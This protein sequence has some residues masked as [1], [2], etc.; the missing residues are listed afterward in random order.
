MPDC[1]SPRRDRRGDWVAI[2]VLTAVALGV[3]GFPALLGRPALPGDD[4][5][6]NYPLRV[7]A[8]QQIRAGQ[9]P[10]FDPYIWSGAPL[11]AGW[12]AAAAYPMTWLFAVLPGAAAWTAGLMATYEAAAGGMYAF[13]RLGLRLGPAASFAGALT[14]A[15]G[16]Q[17]GAQAAHFGLVAG[18]SWAPL[19]LLAVA[20]LTD[21]PER[22]PAMSAAAATD[23]RSLAAGNLA[24]E[25]SGGPGIADLAAALPGGEPAAG[26]GDLPPGLPEGMRTASGRATAPRGRTAA[27]R[28]MAVLGLAVGLIALAGEPRAI[29]DG[30]AVIAGY[31]AWQVA[32]LGRRGLGV[33]CRLAGGLA[34]GAALGAAQLLPGLAAIATSQRA[35]SSLALFSS[36]SLPDRWLLLMLAPD[37]LGG[38]GT[39][40]QPAFFGFY[41]LTEVSGYVGI[42]PLAAALALLARLPWAAAATR[43]RPAPP[44]PPDPG[45]LGRAI[46]TRVGRAGIFRAAIPAQS[47]AIP[48]RP[49]VPDWLVWHVVALSGL[50]LALGGNTPLGP[51]LARLPFLGTQRLQSRNLLVLDLALAVLLAYWADRPPPR[52]PSPR[53]CI[54]SPRWMRAV[55]GGR[56]GKAAE[57]PTVGLPATTTTPLARRTDT[58]PRHHGALYAAHS[59]PQASRDTPGLR[60]L[61]PARETALA[62]APPIAVIGVAAA[63]LA[64]PGLVH[65]LDGNDPIGAGL[66]GQLRPWLLPNLALGAGT[67]ALVTA[68]QRLAKGLRAALITGIVAVDLTVYS[69]LAV[70]Q[71]APHPAA[72]AS[73]AL[74]PPASPSAGRPAAGK[75]APAPV[76]ATPANPA[77]APGSPGRTSPSA[78][79]SRFAAPGAEAPASAAPMSPAPSAAGQAFPGASPRS[80]ARPVADLGY[81]GRF[82]IYDPDLLDPADLSALDPPDR[83]VAGGMASVQGY[84]SIVDGRYAAA[85]GSHLADGGGQ[86]TLSL[87]AISGAVLDELDTT[88]LLTLPRYAGGVLRDALRLPHWRP[89]GRDGPFEVFRNLRARPPLTLEA[90]G[91]GPAGGASVSDVTGPASTDPIQATVRDAGGIRIVRSVSGITGWTASWHPDGGRQAAL[92]VRADGLVQA[93]D[94]PPGTGVLTWRYEPPRLA[95]G[96]G[97]S[98]AA[99]LAIAALLIPARRPRRLL[100]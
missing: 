75:A 2:G 27:R 5:T 86:D 28:W 71:I 63:V 98:V 78:K 60:G 41:N 4:M 13:L 1:R 42:L 89:A 59:L 34:L 40:S 29:A 19:A 52:R 32:R 95:E 44:A 62:A 61:L 69:V 9:L 57:E 58:G 22:A 65:W 47:P 85:T 77:G 76:S 84:S 97:L 6:Q 35:G 53:V 79:A 56:A 17:M 37:L 16:G 73:A 38:S 7:L 39:L 50:A 10:L 45:A 18:M 20:R 3:F 92:P 81:P 36:G 23:T 8:G 74:L 14:F 93:V 96:L 87:A 54:Q 82:A 43:H 90:L 91:G 15:F 24:G 12:N 11:L 99:A 83:N 33:A 46:A 48:R 67:L 94:V 26:A 80:P 21:P 66:T 51:A 68:G 31:G 64:G 30:A 70:A 55:A 88:V 100:L 49:A 25:T 72:P